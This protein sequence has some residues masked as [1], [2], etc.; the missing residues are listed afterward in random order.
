[1]LLLQIASPDAV[2]R[3][4]SSYDEYRK[5]YFMKQEHSSLA[6]LIKCIKESSWNQILLQVSVICDF[7]A[8]RFCC[9][10]Y[11][12]FRLLHIAQH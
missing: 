1:M 12:L 2:F 10:K 4:D 7:I 11:M 9:I 8:K 3:L 5:I 6:V